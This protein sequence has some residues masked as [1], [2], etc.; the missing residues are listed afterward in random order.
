[1]IR[2]LACRGVTGLA[3]TLVLWLTVLRPASWAQNVALGRPVFASGD[4][5]PGLP[6]ANLT[7]GGR[8]GTPTISHPNTGPTLGFYFQID[9]GSDMLLNHLDLYNRTD[10]AP[11]RLTNYRVTLYA[12]AAGVPGAVRWQASVRT[13]GTNSGFGGVDTLVAATSANPAHLFQG[14][15][16]R[17][18]NLSGA[19]YNPQIADVE[20]FAEPPPI[21]RYFLTTAGNIGG[22]GL[23]PNAVLSWSVANATSVTLSGLGTVPATGTLTVTPAT[24][25]TYTLTAT[26]VAI[27]TA[28]LTIAVNA[29]VL[30]P[31]LNEFQAAEGILQDED[32][33]R[34]D[35]ME[36]FN[37]NN[38]TLVLTDYT[39]TDTAAVAD[40]WTFPQTNLPPG[41][42]LLVFASGK[43]RRIPGSSLHTNFSLATAGE[44]MGFRAPDGSL[45]QQFPANYPVG[46]TY[47]QQTD[48][49]SYGL[50]GVGMAKY[51]SPATPGAPNGAGLDGVVSGVNF[52]IKRGIYQA[53][54]TVFMNCPTNGATLIYTTD[55][56]A[57]TPTN[58]TAVLPANADSL[59]AVTLTLHPG[60]I[61]AGAPGINIAPSNGTTLLRAAAFKTG[62][63]PSTVATHTYVFPSS[64]VASPVMSTSITQHATYGPQL[65]AALT[66]LPSFS[67]VSTAPIAQ[68]DSVPCSVEYLPTTGVGVQ[69]NGGVELYGGEFSDF[70]K[71]SFRLSFK[72][73]Y[74]NTKIS[75]PNLFTNHAH[76]WKP[77]GKFNQLELRGGSHDM[78][79]R[80]FYMSNLFTDATMFDL[81]A[82]SVHSRFVHLYL[83]GTYWGLYQLRERWSADHHTTYFGGPNREHE[84][85][86]GNYNVGGWAEP[87]EVYDGD[88]TA[89]ARILAQR[90]NYNFLKPYLDVPQYVDYMTTWM[91]GNAEDEY[92]TTGPAGMGSG[93]KFFLND[94][95]GYLSINSYDGNTNNTARSNPPPGHQPGDGPGSLL[96]S[97][98]VAGD[99][100]FR[101]LLGDRI[102]HAMFGNGALTATANATRLNALCNE[103]TRPFYAES[104]RWVDGGQSRTPDSWAAE[105]NNILTNW[106][107]TRTSNVISQLRTVGYYPNV[108]AP[109]F[110]GGTVASGAKVFFLG[111][112][113]T[114]SYTKDGSDPRLPG[115]AISPAA[116]SGVSA[117]ITENTW[118]RARTKTGAN[119]SALNEAFYTV[120]TPLAAGDVYFS[121]IHYHPLGDD[122]A[123]FIELW[124]PTNH[125]INLRGAK[126]TSGVSYDFP[127]NRD[128]PLVPGGRLVLVASLF[129]F[130]KSYGLSIPVAGVYFDRLDN[131]G[132]ILILTTATNQPLVSVYYHDLPPW[133][134]S[135]DGQGYSLVLAN[136]AAAGEAAS[137]RT[138][139]TLHG[140][141]GA[142]ESVS[143][144]GNPLADADHDGLSWLVESFLNTSDTN[145]NSGP[146]ALTAGLTS[147][148]RATLTF[149]RRLSADDLTYIVEVSTNLLDWTADTTRTAHQNL[150]NGVAMETWA[151]TAPEA[152]QFLR[153]RITK[154]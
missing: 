72:A 94:A 134:E 64:V 123:E 143:F 105:K 56:S 88:G 11:E 74:G 148:Q 62:F 39:L 139:T 80:G 113:G 7:D 23:P 132:E 35:W 124:N 61:P 146:P 90:T 152:H 127:D 104:A 96:S 49:V 18:E 129:N 6:A 95:D 117:T 81:G 112:G 76:G 125:A 60:A 75:I 10:A 107:P 137:W 59:P 9:L 138:S 25:T 17:I 19:A 145:G 32:G 63:V 68:S 149:P 128:V 70:L 89:W 41:G 131:D 87:G 14:R 154:P 78:Q 141:P 118:L 53:A 150:G 57:P 47:P 92:R 42:Y 40:R 144:V 38:Y 111:L 99:A 45:V 130:Q 12:D 36:F 52:S 1:M 55:G 103:I 97:L 115:G 142:G 22:P 5:W 133:P 37:P 98:Y 85:I 31:R 77:A 151:A 67:L 50:D 24:A 4:L 20:A 73:D 46:K 69:E 140:T 108:T 3:L 33:D 58:G 66:D 135:A 44:Y 13:D 153:L 109:T 110:T 84:S 16:I 101:T 30:A 29:P 71:K 79:Q 43:D 121:E 26:K 65:Q 8:S 116:T 54:Q 126:F 83:N 122:D 51:F 147:D 120:T 114:V 91:F 82:F 106:L 93:F 2:F 102:H 27:T 100:E 119:W 86:N 15:F 21:I 136:R 28:T 48:R 34:S